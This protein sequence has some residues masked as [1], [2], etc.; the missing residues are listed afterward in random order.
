MKLLEMHCYAIWFYDTLLTK[1]VKKEWRTRMP[2]WAWCW[3]LKDPLN[4]FFSSHKHFVQYK[5]CNTPAS[6]TRKYCVAKIF[7]ILAQFWWRTREWADCK[8][9]SR[10]APVHE[11]FS[12]CG[13]RSR[14]SQEKPPAQILPQ[15]P[16]FD[17]FELRYFHSA[18]K[19]V[20]KSKKATSTDPTTKTS[21][22]YLWA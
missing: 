13:K 8:P 19:R 10:E 16:L 3:S 6:H 15:K 9:L 5:I 12:S 18:Q 14:K 21:F 4:L 22:W 2:G 11:R 17:I 7:T 1:H 20:R